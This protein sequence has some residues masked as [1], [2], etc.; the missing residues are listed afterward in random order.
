MTVSFAKYLLVGQPRGGDVGMSSFL[1]SG[2]HSQVGRVRMSP[3]EPNKGTLV[4]H[5]GRG[6]GFPTQP[7]CMLIATDSV[8]LVVVV[9]KATESKG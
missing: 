8:L 1:P 3:C 6:A 5:S 2:S 7:L 4:E 9:T